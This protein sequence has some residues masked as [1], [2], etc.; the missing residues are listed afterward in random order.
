MSGANDLIK[1]FLMGVAQPPGEED[2]VTPCPLCHHMALRWHQLRA[3]ASGQSPRPEGFTDRAEKIRNH[4]QKRE[5]S[6]AGAVSVKDEC[7]KAQLLPD[8]SSTKNAA[9]ARA[10]QKS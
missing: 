5:G 6:P 1:L 10:G 7:P 4:K 9:V 8:F 2:T 3:A